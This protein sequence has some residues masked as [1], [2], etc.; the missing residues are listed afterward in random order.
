MIA[1]LIAC[2]MAMAGLYNEKPGASFASDYDLTLKFLDKD[3]ADANGAKCL[4]GTNPGYYYRVGSNGDE[5]KWRIH[6]RGG[7]WCFT[8]ETCAQRTKS[9]VGTSKF[10]TPNISG[11]EAPFGFMNTSEPHF[12]NWSLAY[13]MY[14]DGSSWTSNRTDSTTTGNITVWHRGRPNLYSFMQDIERVAGVMSKSTEVVLTGTSAG[15]MAEYLNANYLRTLLPPAAKTVL[16]PDAGFFL[17]SNTT[18]NYNYQQLQEGWNIWNSKAALDPDCIADHP[19]H[20]D[21]MIPK[22]QL[23]YVKMPVFIMQSLYDTAQ[24]HCNTNS[25]GCNASIAQY[26]NWLQ[27][28]IS[29]SVTPQTAVFATACRQHEE[30]CKDADWDGIHVGGVTPSSAFY[31]FYH[32]QDYTRRFDV[33]WPNNPTCVNIV[34]GGC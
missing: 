16:L 22:V 21:C 12:G 31:D 6:L 18:L 14:C 17:F 7:A 13:V 11:A 1:A 15:G 19:H 26:R 10:L 3:I 33:D 4:D 9:T 25:P 32:N 8:D 20:V 23:P 2:G 28:N 30:S 29:N 5:N 34:H 27:T 24:N